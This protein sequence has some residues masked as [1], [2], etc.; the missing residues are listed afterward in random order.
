MPS[1]ERPLTILLVDD[2]TT[3]LDVLGRVL[4][5]DGHTVVQ[6]I[7]VAE[8]LD[9]ADRHAPDLAL[10]DLSLPDGDGVGLA[11]RLRERHPDLPLILMTAYPIRVREDPA[12]G[13]G[14][15]G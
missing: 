13:A 3:L 11:D 2:D 10:V 4:K 6:G 14:S 9:M 7:G 1:T 12:I 8:A 15:S 5:R